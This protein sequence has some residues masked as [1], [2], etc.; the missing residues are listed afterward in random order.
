MK[1]CISS[2]RH[3]SVVNFNP[4]IAIFSARSSCPS[5]EPSGAPRKNDMMSLKISGA[6]ETSDTD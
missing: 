2:M 3:R 4:R 1:L 5:V 6:H